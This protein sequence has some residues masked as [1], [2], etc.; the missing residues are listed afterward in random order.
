MSEN[1]SFKN[2]ENSFRNRLESEL[3]G[4]TFSESCKKKVLQEVHKPQSRLRA[5]LEREILIPVRPFA[6][7]MIIAVTGLI[8]TFSGSLTVSSRDIEKSKIV[9]VEKSGGGQQANVYKN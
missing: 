3:E 4:V 7:V 9:V 5:L 2:E 8:Y 1:N 6:A